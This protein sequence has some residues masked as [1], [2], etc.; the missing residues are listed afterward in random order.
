M[1]SVMS[2]A[3]GSSLSL[4]IKHQYMCVV[5]VSPISQKRLEVLLYTCNTLGSCRAPACCTLSRGLGLSQLSFLACAEPSEDWGA[6]ALAQALY[7]VS[8]DVTRVQTLLPELSP[9]DR[10][11]ISTSVTEPSYSVTWLHA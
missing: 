3:A 9:A 11:A 8:N 2:I 1:R 10:W 4:D 6:G 5:A 7:T